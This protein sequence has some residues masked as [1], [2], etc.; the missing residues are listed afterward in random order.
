MSAILT[1]NQGAALLWLRQVGG[2]AKCDRNG[3]VEIGR[4]MCPI[5]F[6][7]FGILERFGLVEM[8]LPADILECRLWVLITEAG[9]AFDVDP[10]AE[11][12][13]DHLTRRF[14]D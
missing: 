10:A 6:A 12:R 8:R 11:R 3:T 7:A 4:E 1:T 13:L 9:A 5:P 14:D 2:R